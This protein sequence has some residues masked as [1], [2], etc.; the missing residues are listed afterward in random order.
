MPAP[1]RD[2]RYC[3]AAPEAE[4]E[5]RASGVQR[6]ARVAGSGDAFAH[7]ITRDLLVVLGSLDRI[8]VVLRSR[9]SGAPIDQ[10]ESFV[11]GFVD[12]ESS[13]DAVI[14]ASSLET[15]Q[16]LLTL[17]ELFVRGVIAFRS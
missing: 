17:T 10:R 2:E 1:D 4:G 12:G 5:A 14:Q 7:A 9:L 13:I 3:P 6:V 15:H 16:V 11:L 8:P